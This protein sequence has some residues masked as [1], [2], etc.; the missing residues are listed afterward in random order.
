[1]KDLGVI[2]VIYVFWWNMSLSVLTGSIFIII[3]NWPCSLLCETAREESPSV[4]L[5]D[6]EHSPWLWRTLYMPEK[7]HEFLKEILHRINPLNI[8]YMYKKHA[9]L[10]LNAK[11]TNNVKAWHVW[12]TANLSSD[13]P[14]QL[15]LPILLHNEKIFP[16]LLHNEKI[17]LVLT[18]P[19]YKLPFCRCIRL[20]CPSHV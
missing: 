16:I 2:T 12:T 3:L 1:M 20:G 13:S 6:T 15:H 5:E 7:Y 4:L 8:S 9:L 10:Y 14:K 11:T 17:W 18:S 19:C